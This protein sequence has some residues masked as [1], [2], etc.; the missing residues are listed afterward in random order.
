MLTLAGRRTGEF[1]REGLTIEKI[2]RFSGVFKSHK[3]QGKWR[4]SIGRGNMQ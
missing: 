3:M 1:F 4:K 2:L